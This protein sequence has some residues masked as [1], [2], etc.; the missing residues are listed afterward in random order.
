MKSQTRVDGG[1]QPNHPLQPAHQEPDTG[2]KQYRPYGDE[3]EKPQHVA[4]Y[5]EESPTQAP[6]GGANARNAPP[7]QAKNRGCERSITPR[8][9]EKVRTK[10]KFLETDTNWVMIPEKLK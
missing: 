7:M 6:S 1:I 8:N 2:S 3:Y 4:A 10:D 9:R 5:G